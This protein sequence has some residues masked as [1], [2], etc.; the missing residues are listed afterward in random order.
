MSSLLTTFITPF[1]WYC[2]SHLCFGISLAPEN[3]QKL[4]P[5]R[6]GKRSVSDG[7]CATE[8]AQWDDVEGAIMTAAGRSD[9]KR[10][11]WVQKTRIKFQVIEALKVRD[12][13]KKLPTCERP[14]SISEE[15]MTPPGLVYDT[16]A[17][18]YCRCQFVLIRDGHCASLVANRYRMETNGAWF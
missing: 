4:Y 17:E 6:P 14:W 5:G 18:V 7:W 9:T 2:Y 12:P 13:L 15:L 11:V 3:F 16:N 1:M 10:Q 8:R